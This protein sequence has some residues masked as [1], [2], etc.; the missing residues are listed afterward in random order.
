MHPYVRGCTRPRPARYS[1]EAITTR[2]STCC[3]RSRSCAAGSRRGTTAAS[4][5]PSRRSTPCRARRPRPR[6]V[7][8]SSVRAACPHAAPVLRHSLTSRVSRAPCPHAAP[9]LRHSL[10]SR[11]SRAPGLKAWN[12]LGAEEQGK[13][14]WNC[15]ACPRCPNAV[16]FFGTAVAGGASLVGCML[17]PYIMLVCTTIDFFCTRAKPSL[18]TVLHLLDLLLPPVCVS[19]PFSLDSR[20]HRAKETCPRTSAGPGARWPV[21]K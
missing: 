19:T 3:R 12:A 16:L 2:A 6:S 14:G 11:V 5:P 7:P 21:C 9:V 15:T 18:K 20:H 8:S 17:P 10:T 1:S 4:T 13:H